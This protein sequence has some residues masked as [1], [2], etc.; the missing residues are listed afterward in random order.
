MMSFV[1]LIKILFI[2]CAL[3]NKTNQ[4]IFSTAVWA[5]SG[6]GEAE[7]GGGGGGGARGVCNW[8]KSR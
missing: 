7:G 8:P 1:I 5:A 6:G 2:I 4:P 3:A